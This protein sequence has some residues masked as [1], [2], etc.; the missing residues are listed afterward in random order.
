M[1]QLWQA[2]Y[3]PTVAFF[4]WPMLGQLCMTQLWPALPGP[5][6][7]SFLWSNF[8]QLYMA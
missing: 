8:N 3:G 6:V 1:V 7:A 4:V 5:T 2:L